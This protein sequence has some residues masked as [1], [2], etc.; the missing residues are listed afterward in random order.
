MFRKVL[1]W[2]IAITILA[3]GGFIFFEKSLVS[4]IVIFILI[5]SGI[6]TL[7]IAKKTKE[8]KTLKK[9]DQYIWIILG[10]LV[11]AFS[12]VNLFMGP[13]FFFNSPFSLGS[14]GMLL[15][16]LSIILFALLRYKELLIP[17]ALPAVVMFFGQIYDR[18]RNIVDVIAAPLLGPTTGLVVFVLNVIGIKATETPGYIIEFLSQNGSLIRI[19][20]IIDC[21]GIWSLSA[22]TASLIIVSVA[23]PHLF[24]KKNAP[25]IALGYI[26][27]Y[28]AN[29]L[30]V[31]AICASSYLYGYSG[32]TIATHEHAGWIAFSG[33][34]L[35]FW[36]LFFSRRLLKKEEKK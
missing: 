5:I 22:F 16:G 27:T 24:S 11:C 20:I 30:R 17:S 32:N 26:G 34:M 25:Y 9:R 6:A 1:Y 18:N 31:V 28:A 14:Y 12:F 23:I 35:I 3:V 15:S 36:Y 7:Y 13:R 8:P 21:T 33:W 19:Q 4:D 2:F 29:I 10:L